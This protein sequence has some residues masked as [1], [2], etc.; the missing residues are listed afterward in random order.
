MSYNTL[1]ENRL[2]RAEE[3]ES[4]TNRHSLIEDIK[5][6]LVKKNITL[7]AHYYTP[8]DIQIVAEATGGIVSDSLDMARFGA[9]SSS[10]TLLVAGVR[11][12]GETAKILNPEKTILM[13]DLQA[14]CSLD[15]GCPP[16][17]FGIFCEANK[18]REVVVYANTSASVK[19]KADW[20][21]TSG[22]AVELVAYL[23]QQGKKI[24]WAP[25]KYLGDFVQRQTGA[26][27]LMWD[28]SCIVHEEFK[29][30]ELSQLVLQMS[31][32]EV[33]AHPE[34]S[35]GVLEQAN[36][37]G[38][39]T[40]L[41]NYAK[42]SDAKNL[43]VATDKGIFYKMAK[44]APNKNLIEAPT[45]GESAT[46]KSCGACPWMSM[47]TL[48]SLKESIISEKN[49][50]EVSAAIISEA[51]KPIERLLTFA[52]NTKKDIFGNNDA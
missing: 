34:S 1:L 49:K 13:P 35:N 9:N 45:S 24:L 38:S 52:S 8:T 10:P 36:F 50:V 31:D 41:I 46:C 51:R 33:L 21:V 29:A 43:I 4:E 39:T 15:L 44:A 22:T 7:V 17:E 2:N 19:A 6:L 25:D 48:A 40:A 47:N 23:H 14:D 11:F 27:M 26:D 30:K 5:E 32:V 18:E 28:G 37:I 16:L 42:S 3:Y 12:M 20:M